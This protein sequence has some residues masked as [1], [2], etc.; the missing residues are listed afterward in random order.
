MEQITST[1]MLRHARRTNWSSLKPHEQTPAADKD[2]RWHIL[3]LAKTCRQRLKLRDR[4]IAVLRGLLSILPPQ[5]RPDQMVVYASNRVLIDR[6]DGID[7][8]TLRRRIAHLQACGMLTR[9]TSPNG[10]RYQIRNEQNDTLLTYGIDL[11]PLFNIQGH[12]EALA[13]DCRHEAVRVKVLRAMIRDVLFNTPPHQTKDVQTE[14]QRALRRVLDA[15]QLQQILSQLEEVAPIDIPQLTNMSSLPT[16][17]LSVSDGQNDRHI[18]SSYKD[19]LESERTESQT[20]R[21]PTN[22]RKNA[23]MN[24]ADITV[25]ECIELATTAKA[26]AP[27][28][29]Q[30]WEDLIDLSTS[31]APA[32]G[33]Q[34]AVI[35]EAERHLGRHGCALAILGLVEAFGRIRN[36]EAYLTAL[37]QRRLK[38]GLDLVRMFRS[39]VRPIGPPAA[40]V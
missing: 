11:A 5:A 29:P 30:C 9:R 38:Q 15:D 36:P 3:D 21:I 25:D 1:P 40:L 10:K 14:A 28:Q 27:K 12:L 6:C 34:R 20:T 23:P 8:R 22:P 33:L 31:L 17:H 32:I 13:V 26:M 35:H 18:Q 16:T 4:D 2:K 37:V 19:N 39:L 7:E 24:Q